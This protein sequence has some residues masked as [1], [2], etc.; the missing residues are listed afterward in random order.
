MNL[1]RPYRSFR[2]ILFVLTV[3]VSAGACS[4]KDS[5]TPANEAA[6]PAI[7]AAPVA[8]RGLPVR[9]PEGFVR[10]P[11]T[12][13]D[14][15]L[16]GIPADAAAVVLVDVAALRGTYRA[17]VGDGELAEALPT[18]LRELGATDAIAGTLG[19]AMRLDRVDSV[20]V[21]A[22]DDEESRLLVTGVELL[23]TPPADGAEPVATNE[24]ELL[25]A[26]RGDL[27]L[28]GNGAGYTRAVGS[29]ERLDPAANWSAGWAQLPSDSL[30]TLIS[31]RPA[32]LAARTERGA[33][34]AALGVTRLGAAFSAD[35]GALTV[36]DLEDD[37]ALRRRL[38]WAQQQSLQSIDD[39]FGS[40][41]SRAGLRRYAELV[42]NTAWSRL[43]VDRGEDLTTIRLLSPTCGGG[44]RNMMLG[45]QLLSALAEPAEIPDSAPLFENTNIE[46]AEGCLRIPG[47]D[48]DIAGHLARVGTRDASVGVLVIAD[49]DAIL[50]AQ[51]PTAFGILPYAMLPGDVITALGAQPF[52]MRSLSD[53]HANALYY[54]EH[55][56]GRDRRDSMFVVPEGAAEI[57]PVMPGT[58]RANRP[59]IGHTVWTGDLVSRFDL[60]PTEDHPWIIATERLPDDSAVVAVAPH[61]LV[62]GVSDGI[63]PTTPF[64]LTMHR[65]E[66][67]AASLT[68]RM[69]LRLHIL[70]PS[71][72]PEL[73]ERL[74][75]QLR[76]VIT[77]GITRGRT[78]I[79]G[80][81]TELIVTELVDLVSR[82]VRVSAAGDRRID[83]T[84]GIYGE[85][86][87]TWI[88][89]M[90][91]S[92]L[93][94]GMQG[95][96]S[97][98]PLQV[99]G[100]PGTP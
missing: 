62:A 61:F 20:A 91:G 21:V 3:F 88:G 11:A 42:L 2:H 7:E 1:P 80:S 29:G 19:Q 81:S 39:A 98:L 8:E 36:A 90:A 28:L 67:V 56:L 25:M 17:L 46:V 92:V 95:A 33:P 77:R 63:D 58:Q 44:L 45:A 37:T 73:A 53:E 16:A 87:T 12:R 30:F 27:L 71:A 51:L 9:G 72:A 24:G 69:E 86:A 74:Q 84:F 54:T 94:F 66:T 41:E 59:N 10:V 6:E 78:A 99:P 22:F 35:G 100:L 97:E 38:G 70:V 89:L 49:L 96:M 18:R 83:V 31:L 65:A 85:M 68:D 40:D 15:L 50:R 82:Q 26:R 43:R 23:D 34:I 13:P 57:L 55:V 5:G 48:P 47:S 76:D 60:P 52:G 75:A 79:A 4:T 64:G 93:T 32:A 14:S